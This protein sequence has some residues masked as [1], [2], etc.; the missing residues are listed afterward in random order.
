MDKPCTWHLP[1]VHC[2]RAVSLHIQSFIDMH[3]SLSFQSAASIHIETHSNWT[4]AE[5]AIQSEFEYYLFIFATRA[6]GLNK[7]QLLLK[8]RYYQIQNKYYLLFKSVY[9]SSSVAVCILICWLLDR[10]IVWNFFPT[11]QLYSLLLATRVQMFQFHLHNFET[12]FNSKCLCYL[13][14]YNIYEIAHI[15]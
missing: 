1:T 13:C 5:V 11:L 12:N 7:H 6:Y 8:L 4:Y 9:K 3:A 15:Y 14:V 10:G 2:C